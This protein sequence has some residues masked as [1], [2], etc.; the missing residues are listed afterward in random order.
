[1]H[2]QHKHKAALVP[3]NCNESFTPLLF[4]HTANNFGLQT[5]KCNSILTDHKQA[6][7]KVENAIKNTLA[8][9]CRFS[10]RRT[11]DTSCPRACYPPPSFSISNIVHNSWAPVCKGLIS[12]FN[13]STAHKHEPLAKENSSRKCH[14]WDY[15]SPDDLDPQVLSPLCGAV[16]SLMHSI[17][18]QV[19]ASSRSLKSSVLVLHRVPVTCH[20]NVL[21]TGSHRTKM[22]LHTPGGHRSLLVM[23]KHLVSQ[24]RYQEWWRMHACGTK[25]AH[26][27]THSK[28]A[29]PLRVMQ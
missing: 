6:Q 24:L 26:V 18:G 4:F 27:C 20:W 29:K 13:A 2:T 11:A 1:M 12:C 19:C 21:A 15:I 28:A 17:T 5:F 10:W 8:Q 22:C 7:Q 23:L 25:A 16:T 14:N 3:L 9:N